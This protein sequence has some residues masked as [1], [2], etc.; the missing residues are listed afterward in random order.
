MIPYYNSQALHSLDKC[1]TGEVIGAFQLLN[2][3][4]IN[5]YNIATYKGAPEREMIRFMLIVPGLPDNTLNPLILMPP[6]L[7]LCKTYFLYKKPKVT[8]EMTVFVNYKEVEGLVA[9][10]KRRA[11]KDLSATFSCLKVNHKT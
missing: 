1:Q 6:I 10:E 8:Y 3:R 7:C 9:L 5:F 4:V 11:G 2:T